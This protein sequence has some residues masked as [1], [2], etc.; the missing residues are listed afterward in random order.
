MQIKSGLISPV[1]TLCLPP[2][3]CPGF[4]WLLARARK[5]CGGFV[6][7]CSKVVIPYRPMGCGG[8]VVSHE[9]LDSVL[10]VFTAKLGTMGPR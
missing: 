9:G 1:Q 5:F 3:H 4:G 10:V 2:S 8:A 7:I 6:V